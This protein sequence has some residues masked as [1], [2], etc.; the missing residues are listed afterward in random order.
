VRRVQHRSDVV[1]LAR[2]L[3]DVLRDLQRPRRRDAEYG[4]AEI[5]V[6]RLQREP[7]L[8]DELDD[9]ALGR[10]AEAREEHA[11]QRPVWPPHIVVEH[12]VD[13]GARGRDCDI[14]VVLLH[15]RVGE[16]R[17][18][19]VVAGVESAVARLHDLRA[20]TTLPRSLS[21][22]RIAEADEPADHPHPAGVHP[23]H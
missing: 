1:G 14:D 12:V 7:R 22:H 6:V 3:R 10:S 11:R 13:A 5:G 15:R 8:A 21:V 23:P 2:H 4:Q 17:E 20:L 19:S 9:R 18:A 16:V